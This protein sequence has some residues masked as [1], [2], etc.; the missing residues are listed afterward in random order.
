[1]SDSKP[2]VPVITVAYL[3]NL[4]RVAATRP[5]RFLRT[6]SL[7][8]RTGL[9]SD[10][11]LARHL[12]YVVEA[13]ALLDILRHTPVDHLHAHFGTN[14]TAVAMYCAAL[15]GPGYSFTAHGTESFEAPHRIRLGLKAKNARFAVTVCEYG[16]SELIASSFSRRRLDCSGTMWISELFWLA[17]ES[18][19]P[20]SRIGLRPWASAI[21]YVWLAG[22]TTRA[23]RRF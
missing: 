16:R 8:V 11:G 3:V 1:M 2:E 6:L 20:K 14:A 7:A 5:V 19:A 15:G 22:K 17:M 21:E 4:Y 9:G 18:S 12:F 23:S 13:C 10:R